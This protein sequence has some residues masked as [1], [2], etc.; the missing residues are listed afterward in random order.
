MR[1]LLTSRYPRV[2]AC[3]MVAAEAL[4][5]Y[6]LR[7]LLSVL[8]VVLGV[9]AVIAMMS[10]NEGARRDALDQLDAIGLDN[11]VARSRGSVVIGSPV[12]P[13]TAADAQRVMPLVPLARTTSALVERYVRV[14]HSERSTMAR[15]VGVGATYGRILRLTV[16]RGRFLAPVDESSGARVCVLG[17][18]LARQLFGYRDPIGERIWIG[19]AV[20]QVIGLLGDP[21][22][23]RPA[24]NAIAW[25]DIGTAAIVP[26]PALSGHTVDAVPNQPVDEI[27]LQ[28]RDGERVGVLAPLF[29]SALHQ[30]HPAGVNFDLVVPREL[31]A[32][33]YRT[34]RT[35]GVVIGSIAALA[36]LVGG[37]GI[38]NV[39]LMSVIERTH[40][41]GIRR[42]AGATRRDI[43]LQFLTEALVMTLGGGVLGIV[44]GTT[45]STAIT[46]YAGWRTRVS[47]DAIV[48]AFLVSSLVGLVFGIYPAMKAAALEP[49]DAVRYE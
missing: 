5:R 23:D 40:E 7:T 12:H 27:W 24:T 39:M 21:R 13:L 11:L 19:P 2:T 44:L 10:V 33:R 35:F 28:M 45:V 36:L 6:R 30:M 47:P 42:T 46:A 25:R 17:A 9:A 20:F 1:A 15:V 48:L 14:A 37:I 4:S 49:A 38:M 22:G 32:E 29:D 43:T 8:G 41:I 31:L 16:N 34:Q 18:S 26:L 3:L